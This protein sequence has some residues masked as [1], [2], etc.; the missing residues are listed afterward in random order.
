MD[1]RPAI[2]SPSKLLALILLLSVALRVALALY[3]GNSVT[4]TRGGTYDQASYDLLASRL[5]G[6][7]GFTFPTD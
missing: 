4:E 7:H 6:G 2:P 5:A 1:R 3:L